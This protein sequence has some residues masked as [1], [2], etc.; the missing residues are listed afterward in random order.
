M[1]ILLRSSTPKNTPCMSCRL[2]NMVDNRTASA[3]LVNKRRSCSF[4]E[5]PQYL[6][7]VYRHSLH[8]LVVYVST[9]PKS[10]SHCLDRLVRASQHVWS[11]C[12][13]M[14]KGI[15]QPTR[16]CCRHPWLLALHTESR[17]VRQMHSQVLPPFDRDRAN[18]K[19]WASF[20]WSGS[21]KLEEALVQNGRRV[22]QDMFI[23]Q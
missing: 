15:T 18:P 23:S 13:T 22:G 12:K 4:Q 6:G 7:R 20:F 1:A 2:C 9:D 16:T 21:L 10:Y 3:R 19:P 11:C 5:K 8:T 14:G 17:R